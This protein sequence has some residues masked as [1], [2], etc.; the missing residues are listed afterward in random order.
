MGDAFYRLGVGQDIILGRDDEFPENSLPGPVYVCTPADA[1]TE[2]L[3]RVPEDRHEDLVFV[4]DGVIL[5]FLERELGARRV[6][7]LTLLLACY[8]VPQLGDDPQEGDGLQTTVNGPGKWSEEVVERLTTSKLT[9]R[10]LGSMSFAQAHWEWHIWTAAY[11]LVGALHGGCAVGVVECE[12]RAEA[13][14]VVE[15]LATAVTAFYPDVRWDRGQLCQRLAAHARS[16]AERPSVIEDFEWRN[17][18]FYDFSLRARA[19][20]RRDPCG[21]HTAGLHTLGLVPDAVP[22]PV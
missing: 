7:T 1:L 13:D 15:E 4:Q 5:P 6:P 17:G 12:H 3:A 14:A 18:M 9:C 22:V 8:R 2:V 19:A 16:V 10:R 21:R 11:M 20:G